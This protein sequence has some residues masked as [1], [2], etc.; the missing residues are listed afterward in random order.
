MHIQELDVFV[1]NY[2]ILTKN[3]KK[4]NLIYISG[5]PYRLISAFSEDVLVLPVIPFN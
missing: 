2:L 1:E 4:Q 5:N 3:R